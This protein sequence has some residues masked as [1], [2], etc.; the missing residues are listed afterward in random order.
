MQGARVIELLKADKQQGR[1]GGAET[2]RFLLDVDREG[3]GGGGREVTS[4]GLEALGGKMLEEE[5]SEGVARGILL[6]G[7]RILLARALR[8]QTEEGLE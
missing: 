7:D 1:A 8:S 3:R 5:G 4:H 2:R 6:A